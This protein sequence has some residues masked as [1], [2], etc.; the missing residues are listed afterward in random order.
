M[1][2]KIIIL[3]GSAGAPRTIIELL[4]SI[5]K[6][7]IPI[8]IALHSNSTQ[9]NNLA[10]LLKRTTKCEIEIIKQNTMLNN[11]IYL[12][13]GGKNIVFISDEKLGVE[14]SSENLTPSIDKL[15]SSLKRI[16]NSEVHVFLLGGLGNDGTKGLMEIEH[17]K[18]IQIYLQNNA[19]FKYMIESAQ[20]NLTKYKLVS[21][22]F[23][24]KTL[25]LLN[26]GENYA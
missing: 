8:I 2:K 19:K 22:D 26:G 7:K 24:K 15:L 9:V 14:S 16:T 6:L 17:N 3:A 25:N 18:N 12:P 20:K 21:L 4:K 10:E 23:I 11:K 13:F 5:K 1:M